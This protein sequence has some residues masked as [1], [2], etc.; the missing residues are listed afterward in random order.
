MQLLV[1]PDHCRLLGA[2]CQVPAADVVDVLELFT[3]VLIN[4][5]RYGL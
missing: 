3:K 4:G 5:N 1:K 2:G